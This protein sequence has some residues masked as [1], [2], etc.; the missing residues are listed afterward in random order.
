V[1][2]VDVLNEGLDAGLFNEL[3]L[4]VG[5]LDLRDVAG[6]ACD[7]QVGEPMFLI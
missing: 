2:L 6:D 7:Q 3:L 1:V 4:A 5:S